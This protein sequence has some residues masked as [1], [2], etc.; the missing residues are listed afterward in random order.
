MQI[1]RKE[2]L[3]RKYIVDG[4]QQIDLSRLFVISNKGSEKKHDFQQCPMGE[5]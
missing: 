5:Q 1:E 4:F 3:G 2:N